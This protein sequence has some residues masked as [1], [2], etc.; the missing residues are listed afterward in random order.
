MTKTPAPH[1][2]T[3]LVVD[4]EEPIRQVARRILEDAGYAVTEASSG[5]DA[6]ALLS[7]GSTLISDG[8]P[9]CPELGGDEM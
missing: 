6:I 8:R 5:L 1:P 9:T 3:V 4:D 2:P 7:Q